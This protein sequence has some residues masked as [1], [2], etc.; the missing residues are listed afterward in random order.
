[1]TLWWNKE[2][3]YYGQHMKADQQISYTRAAH[4]ARIDYGQR[5]S[6][7]FGRLPAGRVNFTTA[8]RCIPSAG[9][10]CAVSKRTPANAKHWP[11]T[12]LDQECASGVKCTDKYTPTFW[13]TK[14]LTR[15]STQVLAGSALNDVDSWELEQKFPPTGTG[16]HRPCGWSPSPGPVTAPAAAPPCPR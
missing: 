8:E 13:S 7:L 1:M 5:A 15:I 10:D 12:P 11:D 16:R 6:D 14:R 2:T 3:N 9:F 4:L